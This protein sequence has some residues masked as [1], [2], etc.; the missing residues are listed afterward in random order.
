[1]ANYVI[2][3]GYLLLATYNSS[4]VAGAL[5]ARFVKMVTATQPTVDLNV[6]STTRSIGVLQEDVQ[7]SKVVTGK[8]VAGVREIGIARV[9]AGATLTVGQEVSSSATGTAIVAVATHYITG[10]ALQPA[11]SGDEIDVLL[12]QGGIKA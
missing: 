11:A 7:Q 1:M 4:A 5:R 10:V 9:I 6:A 8:V 2:D 3:K 12:V